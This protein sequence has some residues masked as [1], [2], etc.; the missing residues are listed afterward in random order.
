MI[1]KQRNKMQ[2]N[3]NNKIFSKMEN[4]VNTMMEIQTENPLIGD[5]LLNGFQT[6]MNIIEEFT[7]HNEVKELDISEKIQIISNALGLDF[8]ELVIHIMEQEK[9]KNDENLENSDNDVIDFIINNS[10]K[11][12]DY[13]NF[14]NE[15]VK[16]N[17]N[18]LKGVL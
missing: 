18:Y 11:I 9:Q 10:K 17:L 2:I 16:G 12:D 6:S 14:I 13:E 7:K 1:L 8:E 5:V 3:E 15:N 4:I